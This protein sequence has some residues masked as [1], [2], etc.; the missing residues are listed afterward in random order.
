VPSTRKAG[1]YLLD[2]NLKLP[3]KS[4]PRRAKAAG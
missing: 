1:G 3:A 4:G 2:L